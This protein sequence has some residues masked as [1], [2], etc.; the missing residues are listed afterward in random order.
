MQKVII[1]TEQEYEELIQFQN[2]ILKRM[3]EIEN[4]MEDKRKLQNYIFDWLG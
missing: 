4:I 1:L 2:E 3:E